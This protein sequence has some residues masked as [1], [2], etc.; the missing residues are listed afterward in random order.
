MSPETIAARPDCC[1]DLLR[2]R[3]EEAVSASI[4]HAALAQQYLTL[5]QKF[6]ALA[7]HVAG[8]V[9]G[10]QQ[11]AVQLER[12]ACAPDA[13]PAVVPPVHISPPPSPPVVT[14]P[15]Q[16]FPP[17]TLPPNALPSTP[18]LPT[19][20]SQT[21]QLPTPQLLPPQ[22]PTIPPP[23]SQ[24]A[25]TLPPKSPPAKTLLPPTV[26]APPRPVPAE[27]HAPPARVPLQELAQAEQQVRGAVTQPAARPGRQPQEKSLPKPALRRI[28]RRFSLRAFL[29]R[30]R[31]AGTEQ[32]GRVKVTAHAADLRPRL[33]KASEELIESLRQGRRPASISS[34]ITSLALLLMALGQMEIVEEVS[35]P[36]LSA[37]FSGPEDAEDPAQVL[38]MP[39]E[40]P[41]EQ[42][43]QPTEEPVEMPPPELAE[44][45]PEPES[46][47]E[48]EV[49]LQ[50][51]ESQP[52]ELATEP[53]AE[54]P[55]LPESP[56]GTVPA[57][58]KTSGPCWRKLVRCVA[59]ADAD[60]VWWDCR[61]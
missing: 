24:P 57:A 42:Q 39:L 17:T 11:V 1:P 32:S 23:T 60:E 47:P 40:M 58:S 15:R 55:A 52:E 7:E 27:F 54:A 25:T 43:L 21:P 38:D 50:L 28:Q 4:H 34:V 35:L 31:L 26:T 6:T 49:E 53:V 41:G 13:A 29:E 45:I 12:E 37:S 56:V 9:D 5:A 22:P 59:A 48:P 51:P 46:L 20:E 18:P 36:P 2:R 16:I 33:R 44:A 61:Q 3:S 8:G 30:V 19:I 14:G 10:L